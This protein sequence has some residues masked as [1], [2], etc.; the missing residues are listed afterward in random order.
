MNRWQESEQQTVTGAAEARVSGQPVPQ[1]SADRPDRSGERGAGMGGSDQLT[2]AGRTDGTRPVSEPALLLATLPGHA[3]E[4]HRRDA[5][6]GNMIT[7]GYTA[8]K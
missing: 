5:Q 3:S 1:R 2:A 4:G 7:D 8:R 6:I